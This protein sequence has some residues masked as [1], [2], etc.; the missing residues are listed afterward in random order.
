MD[1]VEIQTYNFLQPFI[2]AYLSTV[3]THG[4]DLQQSWTTQSL[5]RGLDTKEYTENHVPVPR[6]IQGNNTRV[7][8]KSRYHCFLIGGHN[9]SIE[10]H[11]V[12]P[13]LNTPVE[14]G[15]GSL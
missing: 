7:R 4:R 12:R 15:F 13:H 11:P 6:Y 5:L 3:D 14:F 9:R 2:I 10:F 1:K 8:Q